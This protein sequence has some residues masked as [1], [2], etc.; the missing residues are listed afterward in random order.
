MKSIIHAIAAILRAMPRFVLERVQIAGRWL[1]RLVAVPAPFEPEA[2]EPAVDDSAERDA[3]HV[4]ALREAAAHLASGSVPP[5]AIMNVLRE[6]DIAWLAALPRPMLCRVAVA[7]DEALMAH[8]RRQRPIKGL[9]ACD[10]NAIAD[11]RDAARME[12]RRAIEA[13][14][15]A[16]AP[17]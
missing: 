16:L 15:A 5:D 12:R 7:T 17:A 11:F 9:L 8:I 14:E 1:Q 6:H 10:A 4:A 13:K 2:P 3:T